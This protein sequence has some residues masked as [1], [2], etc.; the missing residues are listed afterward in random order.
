MVEIEYR[1]QGQARV[2]RDRR[3]G[4]EK[5]ETEGWIRLVTSAIE[6]RLLFLEPEWVLFGPDLSG[7][8]L[9]ESLPCFWKM[10]DGDKTESSSLVYASRSV[11]IRQQ[12]LDTGWGHSAL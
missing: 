5:K 10:L 3:K 4:K 1:P 12:V 6:S 9:F 2:K 7:L 8:G 11:G